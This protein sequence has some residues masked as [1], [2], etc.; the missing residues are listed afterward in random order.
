MVAIH[1]VAVAS[2]Y[3]SLYDDLLCDVIVAEQNKKTDCDG[4]ESIGYEHITTLRACVSTK[5]SEYMD[6]MKYE[7]KQYLMLMVWP[8][9]PVYAWQYL[10]RKWKLARVITIDPVMEWCNVFYNEV[11][12]KIL[13][14]E[15]EW[16]WIQ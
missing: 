16:N 8:E 12:A 11:T 5:T 9:Y 6:N 4:M 10:I 15:W 3:T 7:T 13:W 14:V 2:E 1:D